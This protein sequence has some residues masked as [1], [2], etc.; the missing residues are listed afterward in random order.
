MMKWYHDY[1]SLSL[2]VNHS[3]KFQYLSVYYSQFRLS[4][5]GSAPACSATFCLFNQGITQ[6]KIMLCL[7]KRKAI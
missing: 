4:W 2:N 5:A 6:E 7:V 3:T 1:E